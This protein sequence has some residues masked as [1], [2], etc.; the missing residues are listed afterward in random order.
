MWDR[1]WPNCDRRGWC[2]TADVSTMIAPCEPD[3]VRIIFADREIVVRSA[4]RFLL[5]EIERVFALMSVS[6]PVGVLTGELEISREDGEYTV[7]DGRGVP[8]RTTNLLDAVRRVHY[9]AMQRL[10]EA[11]SDIHWFHAGVVSKAGRA[12]LCAGPRGSGKSTLVTALC[13]RG[14]KYLSDEVAPLDPEGDRVL[15]FPQWP[16]LREHP[17]QEMPPGW[18][19]AAPKRMV[20]LIPDGVCGDAMPLAAIVHLSYRAGCGALLSECSPVATARYLLEQSWNG[21]D[22]R[23]ATVAYACRVASRFPGFELSFS[24]GRAAAAAV[25]LS[26]ANLA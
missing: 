11:R 2:R 23:E 24:D 10:I 4:D 20:P 16:A 19:R 25:D 15:P 17:G 22:D 14:W 18:L 8:A 6:V 9:S 12:L 26:L 7:R 5:A 3:T 1:G 21:S 13:A